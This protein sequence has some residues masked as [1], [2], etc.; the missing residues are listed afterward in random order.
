MCVLSNVEGRV[1]DSPSYKDWIAVKG[2][3]RGFL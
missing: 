1:S 2:R 3:V